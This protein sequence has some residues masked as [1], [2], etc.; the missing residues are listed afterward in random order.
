MVNKTQ[1]PPESLDDVNLRR[2]GTLI[3]DDVNELFELRPGGS[4]N[5]AMANTFY[6]INHRQTLP[7]IQQNRDYYGLTFFT[8]PRLNMTS[9]NIRALRL[10]SPL[11]SNNPNSLP[12]IIRQLLD[13]ELE[14]TE[15]G[16]TCQMVDNQQAFIPILTN[17]LLS[18][19]GWPDLELPTYTSK[20]GILKETWSMV[21]GFPNTYESFNITANFRNMPGDPI[22]ALL[23]FWAQYQIHVFLGTIVPYPDAIIQNEIDYQTRIYRLV[24]DPSKRYVQKIAACGAAFPDTV[25]VGA[26]FNYEHDRPVNGAADQISFSFKCVGA[27]YNDPILIDEFNRTTW[28]FNSSM[29]P[30][31][32][33]RNYVKVPEYLL[34]VFNHAG[35][36]QIDMDTFELQWWVPKEVYKQR[37]ALITRQE[38]S[39]EIKYRG[40]A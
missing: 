28:L 18:I 33:E 21:D 20:P 15:P 17:H 29:R 14:R 1:I 12:R 13:P 7:P 38:K 11:L 36:P 5:S 6:G 30:E 2:N 9:G 32:R 27:L 4:I 35:Y 37:A 24:L 23:W 26:Q 31:V 39:L 22:S 19:A 16:K 3:K 40:A 8:R 25:Q 10:M 34:P